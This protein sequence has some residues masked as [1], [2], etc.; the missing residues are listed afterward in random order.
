MVARSTQKRDGLPIEVIGTYNPIPAP[1]SIEEM[2][3]GVLPVK[4]VSLDFERAKY[5][6]GT[7]AQPSQTTARLLILAGVLPE[8][9]RGVKKD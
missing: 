1:R 2:N 6:I 4:D 8:D 9:W 3:N 5:W 7:G